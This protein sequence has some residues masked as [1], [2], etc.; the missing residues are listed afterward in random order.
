MNFWKKSLMVR[1]V[2]YFLLLSVLTVSLVG[3]VAYSKAT[4][5]LKASVFDRLNAA[6]SIKEGELNRWVDDEVQSV[7]FIAH[8]PI[9]RAQA[10]VLM[11]HDPSD[12]V[13]RSAY[14]ALSAYL[15]AT[16]ATRP[17]FQ[18]VLI[19]SNA[20]GQ[21]LVSTDPSHEGQYRV[22]DRYFTQGQL[23]T[24]VQNVYPSPVTLK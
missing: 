10:R 1:L 16:V 9:V 19:L 22:S 4:D 18:E 8:L 14:D 12:P 5:A 21:V 6:A 11:S 15:A 23:G 7:V 17:D 3:Y 13:Y 20:G 2:S 24:F